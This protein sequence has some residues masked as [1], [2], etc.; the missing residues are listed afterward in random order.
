MENKIVDFVVVEEEKDHTQTYD[1]VSGRFATLEEANHE[2]SELWNHL[3][4]TEK[5]RKTVKVY[6]AKKDFDKTLVG[7]SVD[8]AFDSEN[9]D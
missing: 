2:A 9:L 7:W 1:P 4:S 3:T 8:G 5:K 6:G